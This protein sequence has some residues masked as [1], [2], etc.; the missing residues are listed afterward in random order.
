MAQF[1]AA[2][3]RTRKSRLFPLVYA[4]RELHT[5]NG[6]GIGDGDAF[7]IR[8]ERRYESGQVS[9]QLSERGR[10]DPGLALGSTVLHV[11]TTKCSL[12]QLIL[13]KE[14]CAAYTG[15]CFP[16]HSPVHTFVCHEEAI[17][18]AL[19]DAQFLHSVARLKAKHNMHS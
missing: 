15:L 1:I 11:L 6:T 12:L 7:S 17:A 3:A 18:D 5:G 19:T 2:V 8:Q 9:H 4:A 10:L 14:M 13:Q 16:S